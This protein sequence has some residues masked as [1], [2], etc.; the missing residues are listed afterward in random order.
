MSSA[1]SLF[2]AEKLATAA[3]KAR[4]GLLSGVA[5]GLLAGVGARL[6]MRGVAL[7]AG[8]QPE[9]TLGGTLF[10]LFKVAMLGAAP[11]LLFVAIRSWLPGRAWVKGLAYGALWLLLFGTLVSLAATDD[12][13]SELP[14]DALVVGI[15]LFA[16]LFIVYGLIVQGVSQRLERSG[17]LKF[18]SPGAAAGASLLLGLAG[19]GGLAI[20]L[21]GLVGLWGFA[22]VLVVVVGV[23]GFVMVMAGIRKR[24][25]QAIKSLV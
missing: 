12:P 16:P 17:A 6:A 13:E 22:M 3:W 2:T 20:V 8:D 18:M 1:L 14:K 19:L 5:G 7:A 24:V 10:I 15:A 9:F 23:G 21:G 4:V 25:V 11:G